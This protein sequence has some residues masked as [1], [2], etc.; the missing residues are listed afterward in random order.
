MRRW[1]V[2]IV[3]APVVLW[4]MYWGAAAFVVKQG[5]ENFLQDQADGDLSSRFRK[6]ELQG[7]P[8][9]FQ[10]TVSDIEFRNAALFS[11]TTPTVQMSAPSYKP[12]NVSLAISGPQMVQ[13]HLGALEIKARSFN[14]G[15]F[16][17][18]ELSLP[19]GRALLTTG[20]GATRTSSWMAVEHRTSSGDVPRDNNRN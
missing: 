19:L 18:P 7:F 5:A 14:I 11:W 16:F 6:A 2:I 20:N 15:L 8:T 17:R 4:S 1:L 12:Q 13:S 3:A 10:L 9:K